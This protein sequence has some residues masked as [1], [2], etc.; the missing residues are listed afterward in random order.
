MCE[1]NDKIKRASCD[2]DDNL[3]L[4]TWHVCVLFDM[5]S[6]SLINSSLWGECTCFGNFYVV[7]GF[8]VFL[9]G[10]CLKASGYAS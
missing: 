3:R 8:L 7:N 10:V 1:D 5:C 4:G 9:C 2:D 6:V